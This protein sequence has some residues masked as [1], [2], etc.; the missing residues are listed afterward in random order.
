MQSVDKGHGILF[1][2]FYFVL[3]LEFKLHVWNVQQRE[4]ED[5][6]VAILHIISCLYFYRNQ[7][8]HQPFNIDFLT[9]TTP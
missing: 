2:Y 3:F 1:I 7:H 6:A 9:R 8:Q 5:S 4:S